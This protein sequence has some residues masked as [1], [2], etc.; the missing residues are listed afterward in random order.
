MSFSVDSKDRMLT[1][2]RANITV[3]SAHSG[4]PGAA[5]TQN[6][7]SG[8]SYARQAVTL[9]VPSGG[10][11]TVSNNPQIPVPANATVSHIGFWAGSSFVGSAA[12]TPET[13]SAAGGIY[14]LL[15]TTQ[16]DLNG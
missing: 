15:N 4:P 5:G 11:M 6:E 2:E 9:T 8:G 13:Y 7:L 14:S 1:A 3:V 16:L 12:V 10:A